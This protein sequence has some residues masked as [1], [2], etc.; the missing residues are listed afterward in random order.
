[1]GK[2]ESLKILMHV[3]VAVCIYKMKKKKFIVKQTILFHPLIFG[4]VRK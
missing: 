2:N 1:M 4:I 3:N